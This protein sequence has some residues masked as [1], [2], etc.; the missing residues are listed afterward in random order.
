MYRAVTQC[1]HKDTIFLD[2]TTILA[3]VFSSILS[4]RPFASNE[5]AII[6]GTLLSLC[7]FLYGFGCFILLMPVGC[8]LFPLACFVHEVG[9]EE[10]EDEGDE[11]HGDIPLQAFRWTLCS[12]EFILHLGDEM[13]GKMLE[14]RGVDGDFAL[15]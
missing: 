13:A 6:W 5:V 2:I 9:G 8:I 14:L 7:R 10:G 11:P 12:A 3:M 15:V 1:W 4:P